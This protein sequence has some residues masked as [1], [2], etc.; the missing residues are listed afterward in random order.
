[1]HVYNPYAQVEVKIWNEYKSKYTN[2]IINLLRRWKRY[3][4]TSPIYSND[5]K[6]SHFIIF[7][8][9]ENKL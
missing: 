4:L 9:I 7:K 1:M 5:T 2:T 8:T 6:R 3:D